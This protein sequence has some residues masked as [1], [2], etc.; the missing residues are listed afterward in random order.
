MQ[1]EGYG[2]LIQRLGQ[3]L[4]WFVDRELG[5]VMTTTQRHIAWM[6][7]PD[8]A[9]CLSHTSFDPR[10][11]RTGR[12]SVYLVLAHDKITVWQG[13][14]RTWLG[15]IMRITTRGVASE[16]NPVLYL[17]DEAGNIG[18][19]MRALQDG[20]T[21]MRG[22]GIRIWLFFQSLEQLREC[23]GKHAAIILDNMDT[24]QFFGINS[25]ETA[26]YIS[27]RSG[28]QTITVRTENGGKSYSWPVGAPG[29]EPQPDNRS[30][31]S[32]WSV[33][34]HGRPLIMPAEILVLPE[35]V[36]LTVHRNLPLIPAKLL[37]YYNAKE[38]RNG[39]TGEQR[40]MGLGTVIASAAC[41]FVSLLLA[42]GTMGGPPGMAGIIPG[43]TAGGTEEAGE[44]QFGADGL[45]LLS[46]DPGS[47]RAFRSAPRHGAYR[48]Q[49]S[50]GRR[51][52]YRP[53]YGEARPKPR[54]IPP[55]RDGFSFWD[56]STWGWGY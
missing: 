39:G 14:M 37:K 15:S 55:E 18:G 17:I 35:D 30:V 29:R 41:L 19:N 22:M 54:Q 34:E 7:S 12:M 49:P 13:L 52:A 42:A 25:Y 28:E 6:H 56:P 24:Q 2:G 26:E 5:S 43:I 9:A 16:H 4:T 10:L 40:G 38:F 46:P 8:V 51:P 53:A 36:A 11:L 32:G 47:G 27:K 3:S 21:L 20:I 1:T 31:N 33:A 50:P 23:Y 44:W 48:P 45:S